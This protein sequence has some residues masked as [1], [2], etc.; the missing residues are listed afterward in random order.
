MGKS[1][2]FVYPGLLL[3]MLAFASTASVAA[4]AAGGKSDKAA[5][6]NASSL[7][8]IEYTALEDKV[9]K[10]LVI[11]T[12]NDTTRSGELTRYTKVTLT[13]QMGPENGSIELSVPRDTIRKILIEIPPADPLFIDEK[14]PHEGESG[15]KKN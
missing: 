14:T 6:G 2:K 4:P 5:T 13:L 3:A 7:R 1:Q 12:T 8:E 10:K 11:S 9:G 15:A